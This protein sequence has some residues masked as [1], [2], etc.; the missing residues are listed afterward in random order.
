MSENVPSLP[1][2]PELGTLPRLGQRLQQT[3]AFALAM[4]RLA[5][6]SDVWVAETAEERA[7]LQRLRLEVYGREQGDAGGRVVGDR[8]VVAGD[9]LPSALLI[10][11]GPRTAPTGTVTVHTW[12]PGEVPADY[13]RDH[14]LHRF[15]GIEALRVA[16]VGHLMMHRSLRG[17]RASLGFIIG[18]MEVAARASRPDVLFAHAAPGL[19]AR[20][21]RLGFRTFGAPAFGSTRGIELPLA[22]VPE[23]GWLRRS[24]CLWAPVVLRLVREGVL[25]A[26]DPALLA[27]F[28]TPVVGAT[29]EALRQLWIQA[30]GHA[31]AGLGPELAGLVLQRSVGLT[32]GTGVPLKVEGFVSADLQLLIAGE[33]QVEQGGRVLGRCG[34]GA[35]IGLA[36]WA[37]GHGRQALTVRA[38]QPTTLINVRG[39]SLRRLLQREPR[40]AAEWAAV[41]GRQD[42]LAAWCGPAHAPV[43]PRDPAER[44]SA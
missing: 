11:C 16:H 39:G 25:A 33:V 20:Y 24:A 38:V 18:A 2:L 31:L 23:P 26:A 34:P 41:A 8:F 10:G 29:P 7:A 43:D 13:A 5:R 19:L 42:G 6:R 9:E 3:W 4:D 40:L 22:F 21:R 37:E 1:F 14:G 36:A 35:L 12:G 32:V 30:G 44:A 27:P 17:S 28:A 15:A